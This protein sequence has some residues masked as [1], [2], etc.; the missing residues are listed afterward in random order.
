MG[1]RTHLSTPALGCY[2]F[3]NSE[4]SI[5]NQ[6]IITIRWVE[7]DLLAFNLGNLKSIYAKA[8]MNPLTRPVS[9]ELVL[10]GGGHAH[11]TVLKQFGMNA[12]DGLRITL[13]TRDIDTPYSGMVPGHIADH[14]S[15][16]ECH[17]DLR[18]LVRFANARLYHGEV[19]KLDLENRQVHVSGRPPVSYDV[20][21][22]N[23][24]SRPGVD[25]VPGAEQFALV[26]KPVDLFLERWQGLQQRVV[27]STGEFRVIVIGGGA[28]GVE[29]TLSMQ[30]RLQ[31][32]LK[33]NGDHPDRL[34]MF[35]LTDQAN[36][37]STH[38]AGVRQRF[39]KLLKSRNVCVLTNHPVS[40]IQPDQVCITNQSPLPTDATVFVTSA[41]APAWVAESKLSTDEGGFILVD[42]FLQS[43]SHSGVF[44][45]GDIASLPNRRAKSGVFAVRQG[46]VLAENL[47]RFV[48]DR[49]LRKYQPQKRF[50]GLISTGD[51]NAVASWG[52]W[53]AS[54]KWL[55]AWKDRIDRR[56][57]DTFNCLPEM[58]GTHSDF[59]ETVK[60][61][62]RG[63]LSLNTMRCGGC[64]AKVGSAVLDR[65]LKQLPSSDRNDV[66]LGIDAHEDAAMIAVP[67]GKVLVQSV[68]YFRSF[69]DDPYTFG[70]IAANHALGDIYAMG[71]EPQSA[72][73]MATIPYGRDVT[74]ESTL[75]DLLSGAVETLEHAG[76]VLNGGHTSE[77]AELAFGLSVNGIADPEQIWRKNGLRCGDVLILTKPIGTGTLFAADMRREAKGRWIEAAIQSMLVSNQGAA[78]CL[79]KFDV[80]GCTD[81][82][83]FGV[84]GHL[85]E[86]TR[87][88]GVAAEL[89][90]DEIP[91]LQ[92]ALNSVK[93]GIFSSLQPQNQRQESAIRNLDQVSGDARLSLLFDPQTAG[94]LL[95]SIPKMQA[96][97]CVQHLQT[98]GYPNA[99]VIGRITSAEDQTGLIT[100]IP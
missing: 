87:A 71:A 54:G 36:I 90:L 53:S 85:L 96:R 30:Y 27:S 81:V 4:K 79:Q 64:G 48:D 77:G 22:V 29:L 56:F 63:E 86:M 23:S 19:V 26:A 14:Y 76:A 2:A 25:A 58:P 33:E 69:L 20:L 72:L 8:E 34:L 10:I 15:F 38:S 12:L 39:Q 50:L 41:S 16:D 75:S 9:T 57:M 37:L 35:L 21:S 83:G 80:G 32:L 40:E 31:T 11:V 42:E 47:R 28:G 95:V 99:S 61:G 97:S 98:A 84:I 13:I 45:A 100:I 44:A 62:T 66:L 7:T 68:D 65:V 82:T 5:D 18:P 74:I 88:S 91:V 67:S 59:E 49:P 93:R 17:I 24:G 46:P 55:W 1:L 60:D 73:A 6:V 94:G 43:A 52:N 78:K 92:G 3:V 70:A 89:T 51:K